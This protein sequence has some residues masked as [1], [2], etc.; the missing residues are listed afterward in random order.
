VNY[1]PEYHHE[2]GQKTY[3]TQIHLAPFG[4]VE[5]EEF[6]AALLGDETA[7]E[8]PAPT[9]ERGMENPLHPLKHFILEKTEGTPFFIEEVVQTLIEDGT[10]IGERGHYVLSR[11]VAT[12]QLPTTVQG[13][14][15]ARIDRLVPDE[16]DLL[17][18][19]AII[20]RQFPLSLLHHI[21][22]HP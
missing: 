14:L 17:H 21:I 5:A 22:P 11:Q 18:Q 6:L 19:L 12:L 1:R 13:V 3:Y 20:G 16:K 10:L 4:R 2:W 9:K 8:S 7:K 15:A